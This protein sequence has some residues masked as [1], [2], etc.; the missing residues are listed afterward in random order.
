MGTFL[1]A[2]GDGFDL[3]SFPKRATMPIGPHVRTNIKLYLILLG[4]YARWN[5]L[6]TVALNEV[7]DANRRR[8]CKETVSRS[9]GARGSGD[10]GREA[11]E[12]AA[13]TPRYPP[14]RSIT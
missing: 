14:D 5:L 9:P 4:F 8:R 10:F 6:D 7:V 2:G 12:C 1:V 3:R 13:R 11:D